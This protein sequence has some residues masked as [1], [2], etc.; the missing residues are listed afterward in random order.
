M[1]NGIIIDE[2]WRAVP[3]E[4][5]KDYYEVSTMGRARRSADGKGT[6]AGQMIDGGTN[7]GGYRQV[8]LCSGEY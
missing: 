1:C 4:E 6:H 7:S 8:G 2:V 5:L 3:I